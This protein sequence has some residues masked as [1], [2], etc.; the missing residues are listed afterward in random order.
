MRRV[1]KWADVGLGAFA[2]VALAT[3]AGVYTASEAIILKHYPVPQSMMQHSKDAQA[4]ER[5]RHFAFVYGCADC[6][7]PTL[8]GAFIPDFGVASRNLTRLAMTFSDAAFD[9]A[10]RWGLRPQ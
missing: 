7:R 10:V 8:Q 6:H 1:L 2:A 4:I 9:R 3:L 5:G